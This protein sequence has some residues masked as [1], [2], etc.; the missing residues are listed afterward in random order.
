MEIVCDQRVMIDFPSRLPEH[1][2]AASAGR[3]R[4][5]WPRTPDGPETAQ[6]P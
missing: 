1:L 5:S 3:P 6:R 4:A 2:V